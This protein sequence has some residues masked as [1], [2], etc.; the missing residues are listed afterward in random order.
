MTPRPISWRWVSALPRLLWDLLGSA[1]FLIAA[2]TWLS[3]LPWGG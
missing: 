2:M 3:L 1:L